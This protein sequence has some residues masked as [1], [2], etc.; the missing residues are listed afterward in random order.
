MD[1]FGK[2]LMRFANAID[3]VPQTVLSEVLEM[4]KTYLDERLHIQFCE[5]LVP[6]RLG[7]EIA[8]R[9]EWHPGGREWA[10][11]IKN[12]QGSYNGQISYAYDLEKSMWIVGK[13]GEE[14]ARAEKYVDLLCH[15]L[16]TDIPEYV[17]LTQ[18]PIK[19]S[20]IQILNHDNSLL[21]VLNLESTQ[22]LRATDSLK[23]EIKHIADALALLYGLH[24]TNTIQSV[25]TGRALQTLREFKELPLTVSPKVFLASPTRADIAVTAKITRVLSQYDI[26]VQYWKSD[27]RPGNVMEQLWNNIYTSELGIC[28]LSELAGTA[29]HKY[30][31]NNN[32]VFESGMMHVLSKSKSHIM[33]GWIPIREVDSPNVPFDFGSERIVSVPRDPEG[34]LDEEA[35]S[36][37]LEKILDGVGIPRRKS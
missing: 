33:V 17:H 19:T 24:K 4:V 35:F 5:L 2:H 34:K 8:L 11:P 7:K 20:I 3:M 18:Q 13:S 27:V 14:L 28:Y 9:S 36:V 10:E 32:V 30:Q 1:T 12:A 25:N 6:L 37:E 29:Q 21:G 23:D 16:P 15:S 26:E 22:Y 31:D